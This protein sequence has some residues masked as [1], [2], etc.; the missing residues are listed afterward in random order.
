MQL[1]CGAEDARVSSA[2]PGAIALATPVLGD[3]HRNPPRQTA[4]D[5]TRDTDKNFRAVL[6]SKSLTR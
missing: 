5:V 2:P 6:A 4:A 3:I 1:G